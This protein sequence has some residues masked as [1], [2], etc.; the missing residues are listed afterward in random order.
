[1]HRTI[2]Q[3]HFIDG[4]FRQTALKVEFSSFCW[5]GF[6]SMVVLLKSLPLFRYAFSIIPGKYGLPLLK[7]QLDPYT[8][9]D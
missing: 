8:D 6:S 7:Q 9:K 1:L 2:I 5:R 3:G 4:P